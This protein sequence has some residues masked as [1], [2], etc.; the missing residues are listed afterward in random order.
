[1]TFL[2]WSNSTLFC[3]KPQYFT[4]NGKARSD[5]NDDNYKDAYRNKLIYALRE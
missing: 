3:H 1:M 5:A 4:I 2:C